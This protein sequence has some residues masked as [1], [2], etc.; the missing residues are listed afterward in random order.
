MKKQEIFDQVVR[1]ARQQGEKAMSDGC[2]YRQPGSNLRCFIGALIPDSLYDPK[3][4]HTRITGLITMNCFGEIPFPKLAEY[5][6][7]EDINLREQAVYFL[8]E[9]QDI[10]DGWSVENWEREFQRFA[11]RWELT[12]PPRLSTLEPLI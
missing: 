2:F 5:I 8:L 9:L 1:H 3:M 10:H 6:L 4:E 12:V 11:D 7:P